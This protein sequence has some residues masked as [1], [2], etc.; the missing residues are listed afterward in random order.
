[1]ASLLLPFENATGLLRLGLP[2]SSLAPG[3]QP[4]GDG[5]DPSFWPTAFF[6]DEN[7]KQHAP[8]QSWELRAQSLLTSPFRNKGQ[9]RDI[10][11]GQWGFSQADFPFCEESSLEEQLG[12]ASS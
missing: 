6:R 8:V 4:P 11:P 10:V 2:E 12:L 5:L 1:M 9:N 7:R 3:I